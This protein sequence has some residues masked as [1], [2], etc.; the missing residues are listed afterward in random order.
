M[1]VCVAAICDN[2]KALVLVAD[3]MIGIGFIESEPD[4]NKLKELH[5]GWWVLF[6]GD[7]ISPVFDIIDYAKEAI[8]KK[9]EKANVP[10]TDPICLATAMEA[11]Q[12]SYERKRLEEAE[13]LYL[14]PIGWDIGSLS[15]GGHS[16]LPD[17]GE[18]K[19]R[20]ADHSL[21]IELLVAG[22]SEGKACVFSLLGYGNEKGLTKRHDVPGFHSI[23]SGGWGA[24]FMMYY[25]DM[26]Y[27]KPVR[28]AAYYAL[29]AKLFGEQASGVGERTDMYI[30]TSDGKF[31]SLDEEDTI[32]EKLVPIW[33]RMRPKWL[34]KTERLVLNS[35]KVLEPFEKIR[36]ETKRRKKKKPKP[37]PPTPEDHSPTA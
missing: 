35:V 15:D 10:P 37:K 25:R 8:R 4:I 36:E 33:Y 7:D 28:E 19:S 21:S 18:I 20:V 1:T 23:G 30:A 31:I 29:E 3:K 26:S 32:E 5:K 9:Q 27:K 13:R 22:F 34:G 24:S 17:F 6:A 14:R 12:E 2:G 16:G 11:I